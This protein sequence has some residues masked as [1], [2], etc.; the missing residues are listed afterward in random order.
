MVSETTTFPVALNLARQQLAFARSYTE[1]LLDNIELQDWFA[2]PAGAPSHLAW[3]IGHLA[4]A[5]YGLTLLRIRGKQPSDAEFI[6][7][8]FMRTFKKGSQPVDRSEQYPP[9]DMIRRT[10]DRVHRESLA[11]LETYDERLLVEA[12][13]MPFAVYPNKLGSI[14]FCPAHEMIHA[15]QIGL[16]RRLLGKS[17]VR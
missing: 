14:L 8:D 11:A 5:E 10:F 17:P 9:P 1:T 16:L 13:E 4:M 12:V 6:D 15:G 2:M 3:Q 7:N